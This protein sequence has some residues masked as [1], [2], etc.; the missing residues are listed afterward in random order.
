[1][2][3]EWRF[4]FKG[5]IY[6]SYDYY[7]AAEPTKKLFMVLTVS[8]GWH[9][10]IMDVNPNHVLSTLRTLGMRCHRGNDPLLW[11]RPSIMAL[12]DGNSLMWSF[13]DWTE[14]NKIES[15][16]RQMIKIYPSRG[17][18]SDVT[19]IT[20]TEGADGRMTM[21]QPGYIQMIL[22]T[23]QME[24][25]IPCPVPS[26][27]SLSGHRAY[28]PITWDYQP[29]LTMLNHVA[30]YTRPDICQS[31]SLLKSGST[32]VQ[33]MLSVIRY[34]KGTQ[35]QGVTFEPDDSLN[36]RL[37]MDT[38]WEAAYKPDSNLVMNVYDT[39][40]GYI[41]YLAGCPIFWKSQHS[42]WIPESG[43]SYDYNKF[44]V[45]Q[46]AMLELRL[47]LLQI[48]NSLKIAKAQPINCIA[49]LS[50][51]ALTGSAIIECLEREDGIDSEQYEWWIKCW[52]LCVSQDNPNGIVDVR[53]THSQNQLG[54]LFS[55]RLPQAAFKAMRLKMCGW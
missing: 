33:G 26:S 46:D 27:C 52:N 45:T 36:I 3:R 21:A 18:E 50:N 5:D 20:I 34:L 15:Q 22:R 53:T 17:N 43:L 4:R 55:N 40:V 16:L 51:T 11:F 9:Q 12:L 10:C 1:V 37:Y 49:H 44:C 30:T 39:S 48:L 2:L 25:C 29:V 13:E 54:T 41:T 47:S 24:N 31:V 7:E 14:F 6:R 32:D 38:N 28:V 35:D 23:T 19:D 8:L 42:E